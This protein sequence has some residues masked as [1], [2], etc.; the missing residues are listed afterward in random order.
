MADSVSI[1]P[2]QSGVMYYGVS[3]GDTTSITDLANYLEPTLAEEADCDNPMEIP[4]AVAQEDLVM[5]F[6]PLRH[7]LD[8]EHRSLF[9]LTINSVRW[10]V[11]RG[12]ALKYHTSVAIEI[13]RHIMAD[14]M[15]R[16][17]V[18]M[19]V[20]GEALIHDYIQ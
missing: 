2:A 8:S 17:W 3:M 19:D 20:A 16:G 12:V 11:W 9:Q 1:F 6:I 13:Y 7:P 5:M 14:P 18:I 4:A 15:E 10:N